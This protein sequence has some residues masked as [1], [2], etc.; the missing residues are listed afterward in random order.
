MQQTK[1]TPEL[2]VKIQKLDQ[3]CKDIGLA[4]EA[5]IVNTPKAMG[6]AT[7]AWTDTEA[8]QENNTTE[9]T[10][11]VEPVTTEETPA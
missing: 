11:P 6:M 4:F 5:V 1:P 7:I 8:K 3:Y 2:Q 10:T 9:P